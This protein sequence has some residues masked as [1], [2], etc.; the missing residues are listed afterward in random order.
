MELLVVAIILILLGVLDIAIA[1]PRYRDKYWA[2]KYKE[3]R[4][5]HEDLK[6]AHNRS[7]HLMQ[8]HIDAENNLAL[9]KFTAKIEEY[10]RDDF[11]ITTHY[12]QIINND[13]IL[14]LGDEE[15]LYEIKLSSLKDEGA[16][17]MTDL[18]DRA[19]S[20]WRAKKEDLG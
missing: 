11:E 18:L 8:D 13:V 17:D 14:K 12:I 6:A 15:L 10:F 3:L 9:K 7:V 20:E 2:G 19:K 1:L 4:K 16:I 5:D